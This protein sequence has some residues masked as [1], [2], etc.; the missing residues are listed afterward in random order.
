MLTIDVTTGRITGDVRLEGVKYGQIQVENPDEE[1]PCCRIYTPGL[2]WDLDRELL[3]VVHADED[4]VTVVDLAKGDVIRRSEIKP[5]VSSIGRV[6]RWLVPAVEAKFVPGTLRRVVL[7]PDGTRLYAV[8][9]RQEVTEKREGEWSSQAVPLGLKVI[10][11]EDLSQIGY[12]D[13]PV[14]DLSLSPDGNQLLLAGSFAFSENG[15]QG[16]EDWGLFVLDAQRLEES[17]HLQPDAAF[18]LLGFSPDSRHAY[19]SQP[20]EPSERFWTKTVRV[21]D[22]ETYRFVAVMEKHVLAFSLRLCP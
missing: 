14:S 11:T 10:A 16:Y 18:H 6:V 1:A 7:S 17:E 13:L 5:R 2:A 3:Y 15:E 9:V 22:L 20:F 19:I 8:G 4:K 21:L 12:L